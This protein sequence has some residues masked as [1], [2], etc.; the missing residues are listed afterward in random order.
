MTHEYNEE[1]NL[2][3]ETMASCGVPIKMIAKQVGISEMTLRKYYGD[4]METASIDKICNVANALYMKALDGNVSA[5]TFFLKTQAH[6]REVDRNEDQKEGSEPINRIQ[7]EV[8]H[9]NDKKKNSL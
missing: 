5:M 6:W 8:L 9:P 2:K 7:I 1:I 4:T 3:V